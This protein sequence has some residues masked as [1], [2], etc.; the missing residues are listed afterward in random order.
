MSYC[1]SNTGEVGELYLHSSSVTL[2][3]SAFPA[4]SYGVGKQQ[5]LEAPFFRISW[6]REFSN[7]L[8]VF[9]RFVLFETLSPVTLLLLL[10]LLIRKTG[11]IDFTCMGLLFL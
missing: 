10:L 3:L 11:R 9:V 1:A 7:L 8:G 5:K 6:C 4:E 2:C